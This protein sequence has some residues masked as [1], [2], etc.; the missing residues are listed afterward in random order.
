[1]KNRRKNQ[2]RQYYESGEDQH[3]TAAK[4]E[5]CYTRHDPMYTWKGR[6]PG[7][8]EKRSAECEQLDES[9]KLKNVYMGATIAPK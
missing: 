1:V 6:C 3:H 2:E 9:Q 8:E 5:L 7:K 4:E